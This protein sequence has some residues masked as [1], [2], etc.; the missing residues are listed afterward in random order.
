M[1]RLPNQLP[2]HYIAHL[3]LPPEM[4]AAGLWD[5][6]EDKLWKR[7]K[8]QVDKAYRKY[9]NLGRS[10]SFSYWNSSLKLLA[11]WRDLL[12]AQAIAHSLV[13]TQY[14]TL[15]NDR[16]TTFSQTYW[17]FHNFSAFWSKSKNYDS[18]EYGGYLGSVGFNLFNQ[19]PKEDSLDAITVLSQQQNIFWRQLDLLNVPLERKYSELLRRLKYYQKEVK[20]VEIA[21]DQ[22]FQ[23]PFGEENSDLKQKLLSLSVLKGETEDIDWRV[24]H[25][26]I[27][28][29][30]VEVI[31]EMSRRGLIPLKE[32]WI[33][34][35][36]T[37]FI[38]VCPPGGINTFYQGIIIDCYLSLIDLV[39]SYNLFEDVLEWEANLSSKEIETIYGYL[40]LIY[41]ALFLSRDIFTLDPTRHF[42][43]NL[44]LY[45]SNKRKDRTKPSWGR[46][47]SEIELPNASSTLKPPKGF[48]PIL[49]E[50]SSVSKG[51]I[52]LKLIKLPNQELEEDF[53]YLSRLDSSQKAKKFSVKEIKFPKI[54]TLELEGDF[55]R[56]VICDRPITEKTLETISAHSNLIKIENVDK[57]PYQP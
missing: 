28:P 19:A 27:K 33:N 48:Y 5:K 50:A 29:E 23:I 18:Y 13:N 30:L 21:L 22:I 38:R 16:L 47:N 20:E 11:N 24:K 49:I 40:T 52:N 8:N 25:L 43:R 39:S 45:W 37:K 6:R 1:D 10:F 7:K 53:I 46:L 35:T 9:Q 36:L 41:D 34:N 4:K 26:Q 15:D 54:I 32:D 14:K 17:K 55:E 42:I 51:S 44:L 31:Q 57:P 56:F 12:I 2:G 3:P